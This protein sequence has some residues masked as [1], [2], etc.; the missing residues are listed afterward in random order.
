MPAPTCPRRHPLT[1]VAFVSR[2]L[3]SAVA[4]RAWRRAPRRPR[5][6]RVEAHPAQDILVQLNRPGS[7]R[8]CGYWIPT[9]GGRPVVWWSRRWSTFGRD[10]TRRS[11]TRPRRPEH[12]TP[13]SDLQK[14]SGGLDRVTGIEPAFSA[15]EGAV[16]HGRRSKAVTAKLT[17]KPTDDGQPL[18]I[19]VDVALRRSA[20]TRLCG[21]PRMPRLELLI[22][23][24]RVRVPGGVHKPP[25]CADAVAVAQRRHAQPSFA[26]FRKRSARSRRHAPEEQQAQPLPCCTPRAGLVHV[27]PNLRQAS[28]ARTSGYGPD[29]D[30]WHDARIP[31]QHPGPGGRGTRDREPARVRGSATTRT[32]PHGRGTCPHA[33]VVRALPRVGVGPRAR[34]R[35]S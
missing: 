14:R 13:T 2:S 11:R 34:R 35:A 1:F 17:A 30:E 26:S 7:D 20:A 33:A 10:K 31:S 23:R 16:L 18:R 32:D 29:H 22:I 15:W 3:L 4:G 8:G 9:L 24:F 6:N 21:Q 27:P 28:C 25:T 5:L 12:S 19:A